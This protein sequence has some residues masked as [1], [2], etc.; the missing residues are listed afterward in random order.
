MKYCLLR[1]FRGTKMAS[2]QDVMVEIGK[3][4]IVVGTA[5]ASFNEKVKVL[6][7]QL[8]ASQATAVTPA[9]LDQIVN[10]IKNVSTIISNPPVVEMLPPIA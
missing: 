1:L 6:Q 9:D 8:N 5:V 4:A 7:D 3:L 10:G 2:K